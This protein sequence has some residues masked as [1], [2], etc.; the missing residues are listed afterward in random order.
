MCVCVVCTLPVGFLYPFIYQMSFFLFICKNY[1]CWEYYFH[2][3]CK[4]F[5]KFVFCLFFPML[6]P[7]QFFQMCMLLNLSV[8]LEFYIQYIL[9]FIFEIYK[10]YPSFLLVFLFLFLYFN[11]HST[12]D[13]Y[14]YVIQGMTLN[15]FQNDKLLI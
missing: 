6:L 5:S 1:V 10:I 4:P 12:E 13:L 9:V 11:P 3:F 8:F 14:L 2:K 15:F 7:F